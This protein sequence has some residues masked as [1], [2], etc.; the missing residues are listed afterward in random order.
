LTEFLKSKGINVNDI[1]E[2]LFDKGYIDSM[3]MLEF[4]SFIEEKF[5][6]KFSNEDFMDRRFRTIKGISSIIKERCHSQEKT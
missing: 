4:I 1:E 3:N 2:D 6:I 5:N